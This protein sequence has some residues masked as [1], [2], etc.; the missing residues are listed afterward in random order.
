[1]WLM[2]GAIVEARTFSRYM[3]LEIVASLQGLHADR[4]QMP[5]VSRKHRRNSQ[6]VSA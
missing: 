5:L 4:G 3:A 1:L 6:V 2:G